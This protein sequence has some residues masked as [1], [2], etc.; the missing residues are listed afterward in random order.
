MNE[1]L[2][3]VRGVRELPLFPLSVVLFPG[4]P[5]P[6]HI[7]E[8]RYR[9]MVADVRVT[10]NLFGL[11]YFDMTESVDD[12]PPIGHIG[13]VAQIIEVEQLPD[14]RSNIMTVGVVRYRVTGYVE[15]DDPYFVGRVEF[16]ED[17]AE[18]EPQL[19]ERMHEVVALFERIARSVR[20]LNDNRAGVPDL[21]EDEPER[22]SFLI[23]SAME[24]EDEVKLELLKMRS[25]L[26]RFTRLRGMLAQVVDAYEERARMHTLVKGNGHGGKH[27]KLEE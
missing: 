16:F 9:R 4:L 27:L 21:P 2:D 23:A 22:L 24:L 18:D 17:D 26:K 6:L 5:L 13:C 12:K 1:S 7:F 15:T 14:G 11:S 20:T 8:E 19:K 3:R 25:G 10:N